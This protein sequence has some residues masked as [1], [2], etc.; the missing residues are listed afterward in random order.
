[1]ATF[2]QQGF[3]QMPDYLCSAERFADRLKEAG[4]NDTA[5]A[6]WDGAEQLRAEIEQY[7][8]DVLKRGPAVQGLY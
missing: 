4:W 1:M 2:E 8:K 7:I 3:S 5:D 6:Q